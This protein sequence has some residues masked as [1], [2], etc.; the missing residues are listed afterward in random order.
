MNPKDE[1]AIVLAMSKLDK[2]SP[3][4]AVLNDWLKNLQECREKELRIEEKKANAEVDIQREELRIKQKDSKRRFWGT[5]I[6]ATAAV[7]QLLAAIFAE[8]TRSLGSK[9]FQYVS[10]PRL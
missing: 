1:A 5:V 7:G 8:E 6:T 9:V 4:Y 2:D 10:K 3:E